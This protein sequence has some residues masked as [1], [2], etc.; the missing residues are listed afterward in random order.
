M[1][2]V[3]GVDPIAEVPVLHLRLRKATQRGANLALV[4]ANPTG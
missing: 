2:L 3:V 4:H 1:I